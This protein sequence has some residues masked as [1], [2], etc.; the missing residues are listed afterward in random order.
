[1]HKDSFSTAAA[2][3]DSSTLMH[4]LAA[5]AEDCNGVLTIYY[6][7]TA[8]VRQISLPIG[9]WASNS[10]AL[11]N[12][13]RVGGLEYKSKT[14]GLGVNRDTVRDTMFRTTE[15]LLTRHTRCKQRR[16]TPSSNKKILR[17]IGFHV[18][19]PHKREA[20]FTGLMM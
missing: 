20:K 1:M 10:E 16:E 12:T 13:W 15:T 17:P 9:K 5:G 7:L 6:Q 8:I 19:S 4:D 11:R 18:A 3:V 2:L 14:Q